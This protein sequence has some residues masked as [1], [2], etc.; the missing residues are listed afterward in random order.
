MTSL[1][2]A[3]I[4]INYKK[5]PNIVL[6]DKNYANTGNNSGAVNLEYVDFTEFMRSN[7]FLQCSPT[8]F[9]C[10]LQKTAVQDPSNA[11]RKLYSVEVDTAGTKWSNVKIKSL[12]TGDDVTGDT[13]KE[14]LYKYGGRRLY[15]YTPLISSKYLGMNSS[16]FVKVKFASSSIDCVLLIK[17]G[18]DDYDVKYDEAFSYINSNVTSSAQLDML[19]FKSS[20]KLSGGSYT[21]DPL[22]L[23]FTDMNGDFER[24]DDVK[25]DYCGPV[26]IGG[27][28]MDNGSNK[29]QIFDCN[30]TIPQKYIYDFI[31]QT[32]R[33][34]QSPAMTVSGK[35]TLAN[36]EVELQTYNRSSNQKF[37]YDSDAA[38]LKLVSDKNMCMELSNIANGSG[39]NL[40]PCS[41]S[42]Q[43][44]VIMNTCADAGLKKI[45][46][47]SIKP[48]VVKYS[49]TGFVSELSKDKNYRDKVINNDSII[50]STV[51]TLLGLDEVAV[52][53]VH[54]SFSMKPD[55]ASGFANMNDSTIWTSALL[56]IILMIVV[57]MFLFL[58]RDEK[59]KASPVSRK[60]R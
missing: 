17:K 20:F 16:P 60:E 37:I 18:L 34:S 38:R 30:S 47:T 35:S 57:F 19:D 33:P 27:K 51:M 42:A 22:K 14:D 41:D 1:I 13:K 45:L 59:Q 6:V 55:V 23:A 31:T 3:H 4:S 44:K 12:V 46:S 49:I 52:F 50:S 54:S 2:S 21:L 7:N 8:D 11:K 58:L 26:K 32:L 15:G 53:K 24:D 29:V 10:N 9:F 36:S 48:P 56:L 28:C 25:I 43:Q 5:Y 40:K 39:F